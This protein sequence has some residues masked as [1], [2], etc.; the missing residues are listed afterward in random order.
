MYIVYLHPHVIRVSK[1]VNYNHIPVYC[2]S[3]EIPN[4]GEADPPTIHTF[5]FGCHENQKWK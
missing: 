1:G 5:H 4:H 3:R 2:K